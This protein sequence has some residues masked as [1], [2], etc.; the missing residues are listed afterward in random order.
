LNRITIIHDATE[1]QAGERATSV[2]WMRAADGLDEDGFAKFRRDF[3][4]AKANATLDNGKN[5]KAWA[6]GLAGKLRVEAD[7]AAEKPLVLEGGEPRPALLSVN[8][9]EVGAE[10]L[11]GLLKQ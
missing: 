6:D 1:P 10:I 8:G 11:G 2:V 3:V 4:A 5:L 7:V 9:R